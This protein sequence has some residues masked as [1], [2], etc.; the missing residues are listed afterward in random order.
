MFVL[1]FSCFVSCGLWHDVCFVFCMLCLVFCVAFGV[2]CFV[3]G[4]VLRDVSTV[5][6]RV[7]LC[8]L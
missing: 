4:I 5:L 2:L 3:L 7:V 1:C 6:C 8:G